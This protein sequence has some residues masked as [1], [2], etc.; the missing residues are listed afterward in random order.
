[1]R[2]FYAVDVVRQGPEHFTINSPVISALTYE[3]KLSRL[4]VSDIS[5]LL[6]A[7]LEGVYIDRVKVSSSK[8]FRWIFSNFITIK[9]IYL[10]YINHCNLIFLS[11]TPINYLIIN[12]LSIFTST[13]I[14]THII[15]HGELGYLK[16]P[17]GFGQNIG[18]ILLKFSFYLNSYSNVNYICLGFPIYNQLL[19]VFPGLR[20]HL[21]SLEIPS[22]G[23]LHNSSLNQNSIPQKK[24]KIGSF[25]VLTEDKCSSKIY[26]LARRIPLECYKK[27]EL[28]TIGI[29]TGNFKF[30]ESDFITHSCNESKDGQL[31]P[32]DTFISQVKSLDWALMFTGESPKYELISSG[33]FSDCINFEIPIIA[34]KSNI[35]DDYFK[36]YGDLG[37]LCKNI[38]EMSEVIKDIACG[39]ILTGEFI[40]NIKNAK[41]DI[42]VDNFIHKLNELL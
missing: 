18:A 21:N 34:I 16:V 19:N 38:S 6:N 15:T 9:Y 10:A 23:F 30:G 40:K 27:I 42:S 8:I 33:V 22:S 28:A 36:L 12:I 41:N 37:I 20:K 24:I 1:M 5:S 32:A 7:N 4:I 11:A 26:D 14:S 29:S 39:K 35:L 3:H 2:Y 13:R 25:G 17:N 31:I